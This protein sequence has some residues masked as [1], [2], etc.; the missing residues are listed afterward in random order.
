MRVSVVLQHLADSPTG[1]ATFATTMPIIVVQE[2]NDEFLFAKHAKR[3][4]KYQGGLHPLHSASIRR[5]HLIHPCRRQLYCVKNLHSHPH[6]QIRPRDLRLFLKHCT[7]VLPDDSAVIEYSPSLSHDTDD[8]M[9]VWNDETP[10]F[11]KVKP[12]YEA[13]QLRQSLL[14]ILLESVNSKTVDGTRNNVQV[15][16]GVS[17]LNLKKNAADGVFEAKPQMNHGTEKVANHLAVMS[18][19]ARALQLEFIDILESDQENEHLDTF[20]RT[21]HKRNVFPGCTIGLYISFE[22][23]LSMH[24]DDH[25]CPREGHNVQMVASEVFEGDDRNLQRIFF[26]TYGRSCC[27]QYLVRVKQSDEVVHLLRTMRSFIPESRHRLSAATRDSPGIYNPATGIT[28]R[29][30]CMD[31]HALISFIVDCISKFESK[32]SVPLCIYRLLELCLVVAWLSSHDQFHEVVVKRWSCGQVPPGNLAIAY[33]KEMFLQG[34]CNG[35]D[36]QRFQPHFNKDITLGQMIRSLVSLRSIVREINGSILLSEKNMINAYTKAVK[37]CKSLVIGAGGLTAQHLI[38]TLVFTGA[39]QVPPFFATIAMMGTET[40]SYKELQKRFIGLT[41]SRAEALL[42]VV[43]TELDVEMRVVEEMLCCLSK[44]NKK[45]DA[46]VEPSFSGQTY[47]FATKDEFLEIPPNSQQSIPFTIP[48]RLTSSHPKKV[49]G[50]YSWWLHDATFDHNEKDH[51]S[52]LKLATSKLE[53]IIIPVW[54]SK[55]TRSSMPQVESR[56]RNSAARRV[57]SNNKRV[58]DGLFADPMVTDNYKLVFNFR[59]TIWSPCFVNEIDILNAIEKKKRKDQ[60]KYA[61][62]VSVTNNNLHLSTKKTVSSA[63]KLRHL[64]PEL[65]N[66]VASPSSSAASNSPMSSLVYSS[67]GSVDLNN[68]PPRPLPLGSASRATNEKVQCNILSSPIM[69]SAT[70]L[71]EIVNGINTD[72][73]FCRYETRSFSARSCSLTFVPTPNEIYETACLGLSENVIP[74]S[75]YSA[76]NDVL[77]Q[78]MVQQEYTLPI[79]STKRIKKSSQLGIALH[80]VRGSKGM[81]YAS[82][83]ANPY[84][85]NF[86]GANYRP[87]V[88]VG[89]AGHRCTS[90]HPSLF[91]TK[92]HANTHLYLAILLQLSPILF[93]RWLG[94]QRFVILRKPGETNPFSMNCVIFRFKQE[95]FIGHPDD[96]LLRRHLIRSVSRNEPYFSIIK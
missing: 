41:P 79:L 68:H 33:A 77:S 83:N 60:K 90:N 7:A 20:A 15:S 96:K 46:N 80:T 84:W 43:A 34:G 23:L 70:N 4:L 50:E 95:V 31:K 66:V 16:F 47:R 76:V 5:V 58:P 81:M 18:E 25:N 3:Y 2:M 85:K 32:L 40:Q 86:F 11:S 19:L 78:I 14:G 53:K 73:R 87:P 39:L 65:D 29:P 35:G 48:Q 55:I 42:S 67:S 52:S 69:D 92:E 63:P 93:H 26:A 89:Y 62:S 61:K 27:H 72:E 75:L 36:C 94:R 37:D 21:I 24:T 51:L 44:D 49:K 88:L 45:R 1:A 64:P 57:V 82:L 13:L 8:F 17:S 12:F 9:K 71:I 10:E 22:Q 74:I 28:R 30:V 91:R 59:C 6:Y 38:H 56:T 54:A